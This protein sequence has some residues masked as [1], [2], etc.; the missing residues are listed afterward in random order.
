MKKIMRTLLSLLLLISFTSCGKKTENPGVDNEK[1]NAILNG[2]DYEVD[3][4]L[5]TAD[6]KALMESLMEFATFSVYTIYDYTDDMNIELN[7]KALKN[8]STPSTL[9][10]NSVIILGYGASSKSMKVKSVNFYDIDIYKEE[11]MKDLLG[12]T[13]ELTVEM[14]GELISTQITV[15]MNFSDEN[16]ITFEYILSS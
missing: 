13:G 9:E 11:D 6:E 3:N 4:E 7:L 14:D 16:K 5:L 12:M 8:I 1:V 10:Y 15:V 2:G